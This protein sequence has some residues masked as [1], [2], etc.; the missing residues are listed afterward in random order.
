M[1]KAF[2]KSRSFLVDLSA[3][4]GF[5]VVDL[6]RV[7]KSR[8][9]YRSLSA[10]TG[11]PV[12]TLTRY[13]TGKTAPRASKAERLLR[14]L[15]DNLNLT[16]LITENV[17]YNGDG[18][19]LTGVM[20][21]PNILKIIGAY[22][23]EEFAGMKITSLLPL[24]LLS[25]PLASYLSTAISRPMHILSREPITVDDHSIPII[26]RENENGEVK[27]YWLLIRRG[28]KNESVLTISA[29]T[30]DPGFFNSLLKILKE[31]K[32]ELGGFFSVIVEE[33]K[34]RRLK[35]PPGVKRSYILA[36]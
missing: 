11:L 13:I 32:I 20:L 25:I 9:D 35:I 14:N 3:D 22:I 21:N 8:Y 29:Q 15:L 1:A 26:F 34:L 36:V 28:C 18:V 30:P 27:A 33:D 31:H 23:L 2:R 19:D 6:L 7:L 4:A 5:L 12:S 10:I 24:D 17:E 16:A